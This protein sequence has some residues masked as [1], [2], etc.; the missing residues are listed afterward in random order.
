M[1]S[2]STGC[3][4]YRQHILLPG[5]RRHVGR[6]IMAAMLRQKENLVKRGTPVRPAHPS[7][8]M[9]FNLGTN[10]SVNHQVDP[11]GYPCGFCGQSSVC[12]IDLVYN[13]NSKYGQPSSQCKL[14]R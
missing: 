9:L 1:E 12:N 6:H 13:K 5:L 2:W 7:H 10:V 14:F 11:Q 8:V 4:Q 3:L